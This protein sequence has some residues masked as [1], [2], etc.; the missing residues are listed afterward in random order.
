L[1]VQIESLRRRLIWRLL[2]A[3]L[4]VIALSGITSYFVAKRSADFAYDQALIAAAD[5]VAG[6]V[7]VNGASM[8]FELSSQSERILRSDARDNI[9]F[10]VRTD[11][12]TYVGGDPDLGEMQVVGDVEG[13]SADLRF[14][15]KTLRAMSI[16]Y[17]S[18]APPFVVTVAETTLKRR[19]AAWAIF[20]QMIAPT[21]FVLSLASLIVWLSV[22]GGLQPLEN[23]RGQIE[24]R[25]ELD[26]SPIDVV[27]APFEVRSLVSAVNRLLSRLDGATKA[28]QAF[29]TDAAHQLRT[30]LAGIQSQIELLASTVGDDQRPTIERLRFSVDRAVRLV[31]QLLALARSE[32]DANV[33][34]P[35]EFD[36]AELIAEVA[37]AWVH[38]AINA[39]IDLGF[40]LQP[41]RLRADPYLIRELLENLID[42]ALRYVPADGQ[43]TVSTVAHP[44]FIELTFDDSGPGVPEALRKQIFER[45]YRH[46][47]RGSDDG[48]V[49]TGS[50]L[51]LAIVRQIAA[52]HDGS[53]EAGPSALL[54]GL[55]LRVVLPL[56]GPAALFPT[57]EAVVVSMNSAER[58]TP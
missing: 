33:L 31:N 49:A 47:H 50:G 24:A 12:G 35:R 27:G 14:R 6:G 57:S 39:R 51:G 1:T 13:A 9:Y 37:D 44:A 40:D 45:F 54:G 28:H 38:R 53:A 8:A 7:H 32:K 43:I 23:L 5:D 11:D 19:A 2:P 17:A 48:G 34:R 58:V 21:I 36:L 56:A 26:L 15:G 20:A 30:P 46:F 55:R 29:V 18:E 22:R 25:S 16:R 41:C 10:S 42:N 52:R 3:L 4:A